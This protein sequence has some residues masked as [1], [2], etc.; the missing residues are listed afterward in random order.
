MTTAFKCTPVCM[1]QEALKHTA[2]TA[3]ILPWMSALTCELLLNAINNSLVHILK[4]SAG[5]D[6]CT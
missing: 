2:N 1:M 6:R 3:D 5:A 4:H